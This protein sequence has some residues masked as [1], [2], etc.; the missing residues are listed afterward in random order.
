MK[1][2]F[3]VLSVFLLVGQ[4]NAQMNPGGRFKKFQGKSPK[5]NSAKML[6]KYDENNDGFLDMKERMK[7][8]KEKMKGFNRPDSPEKPSDNRPHMQ[9]EKNTAFSKTAQKIERLKEKNPQK[10]Q[11]ILKKFDRNNNNKIDNSEIGQLLHEQKMQKDLLKKFDKNGNGNL[12]EDEMEL[13]EAEHQKNMSGFAQHQPGL[14]A[15]IL[16]Q[17]DKNQNQKLDFSEW[18]AAQQ[19]G[20]FPPPPPSSAHG[21][22]G[23]NQPQPPSYMNQNKGREEMQPPRPPQQPK[24]QQQPG[25]SSPKP[26]PQPEP[27]NDDAGLLDGVELK[28]D[29]QGDQKDP[30]IKYLDF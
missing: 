7:A 30:D 15:S 4:L 1:R 17:F 14:F 26:Q 5:D 6:E 12:D 2:F 25:Q 10:Y 20:V 23:F 29:D 19:E 13:L 3:T 28:S 22:T 24:Q 8:R 11:V 9:P 16:D 27:E 18:V 21:A